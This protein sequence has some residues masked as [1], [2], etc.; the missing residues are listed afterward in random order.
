MNEFVL[1]DFDGD[2][3]IPAAVE[4]DFRDAVGLLEDIL[5]II[6]CF[7]VNRVQRMGR[8]DGD[9][10]NRRRVDV[11]LDD[12]WFVDAVRQAAADSIDF[13]R[14]VDGRG[15]GI[16]REVQFQRNPCLTIG[17]RRCHMF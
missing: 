9:V 7:T 1:V 8:L 17:S 14:S 12:D 13:F 15:I 10:H 2:F 4:L 6:G 3:F 11:A 5:E 16:S